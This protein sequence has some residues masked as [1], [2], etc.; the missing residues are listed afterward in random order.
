M[1]SCEVPQN[2]LPNRFSR[3]DAYWVQTNKQTDRQTSK[4]YI[5]I[6]KLVFSGIYIS[7][8]TDPILVKVYRYKQSF[9]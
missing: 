5:F 8:V 4:V 6:K 2:V 1:R 3:F 7:I 9:I